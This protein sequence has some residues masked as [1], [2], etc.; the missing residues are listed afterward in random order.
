MFW[1]NFYSIC[2]MKGTTPNAICKEIGLSNSVATNWKN[3]TMPKADVLVKIA[4][5]LECSTDYLLGLTDNPDASVKNSKVIGRDSSE[6]AIVNSGT[7][8]NDNAMVEIE[9]IISKLT[10]ASR[11]RAIADVLEVLEKYA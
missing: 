10:G 4:E 2:K 3:G 5:L 1:N 9:T 6:I 8:N 11:Y 7:Q